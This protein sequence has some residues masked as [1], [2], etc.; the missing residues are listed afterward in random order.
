MSSEARKQT[1]EECVLALTVR[2]LAAVGVFRR[3]RASG[4][5]SSTTSDGRTVAYWEW[6]FEREHEPTQRN[7]GAILTLRRVLPVLSGSYDE[8]ANEFEIVVVATRPNF[9]GRRLWFL[10]PK[11]GNR[12]VSLYFPTAHSE[13]ACRACHN[14]AYRSQQVSLEQRKR[15]KLD[16]LR[17]KLNSDATQIDSKPK[18]MRWRKYDKLTAE[19]SHLDNC[20]ALMSHEKLLRSQVKDVR[21]LR[22]LFEQI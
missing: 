15:L 11:C 2:S 1:V 7:A 14:L 19:I 17:S 20:V 13:P 6:T 4:A 18:W 9:G 10:C 3:D 16:T 22:K 12:R 21:S 8:Q 5:I